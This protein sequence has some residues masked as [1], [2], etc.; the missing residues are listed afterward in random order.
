MMVMKIITD[1]IEHFNGKWLHA[2]NENGNYDSKS[3][4]SAQEN[5]L[6]WQKR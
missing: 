3:Y 1:E 6:K 4:I 2:M 5:L